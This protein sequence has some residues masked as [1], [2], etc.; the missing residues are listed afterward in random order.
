M[1]GIVHNF[2]SSQF[3]SLLF[4]VI[5]VSHE[6]KLSPNL[7]V[8][9]SEACTSIFHFSCRL[10]YKS[11]EAAAVLKEAPD[12]TGNYNLEVD[13][14]VKSLNSATVGVRETS[15][16]C[17]L[18]LVNERETRNST[19]KFRLDESSFQNMT[20]RIWVACFDVD[21]SN[22]ALGE[23]IWSI[24]HFQT[25]TA[26][27]YLLVEDIVSPLENI[28]L[29][30][31]EGLAKCIKMKHPEICGD[32]VKILLDKYNELNVVREPKLDQF[33][34]VIQ[35]D[36]VDSWEQRTGIAN[37]IANFAESIPSKS[38]FVVELFAFFV[39][40]GFTD[41]NEEV[42]NKMLEAAIAS[43]NF[44]GKTH[45]NALLPLLERFLEEAPKV[46]SLDSVRQ[47]VV[48]LMGTLAK[49]LDK[50]DEK[51]APIID[52]LVQALKMPS[53]QVQEAVANCLPPLVPS[54]KAQVPNYVNMLINSLLTSQSYGERRGAAYGL[55]GI[56]KGFFCF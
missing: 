28:R 18:N 6:R 11:N 7:Q 26:M 29:A 31:G 17:L 54:I 19:D 4:H 49:H 15:L 30:A 42:K 25:D 55:A 10:L 34:R 40:K 52:K 48:I 3:I 39:N 23:K 50:D 33:G 12:V 32:I 14:I 53:Q 46:A 22:R 36:Q 27:C 21:P 41:K 38:D 47:N 37:A 43:L 45:I 44:H 20:H 56:L 1:L 35:T 5:E 24:G 8:L 51:V 16:N 13:V 2:P 9:C